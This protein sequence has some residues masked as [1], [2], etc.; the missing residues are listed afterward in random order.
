M[1]PG[2]RRWS[3]LLSSKVESVGGMEKLMNKNLLKIIVLLMVIGGSLPAT[4]AQNIQG[5]I[6]GM[7]SRWAGI[8]DASAII[9]IQTWNKS[10]ADKINVFYGQMYYRAPEKIRLEYSPAPKSATEPLL[11]PFGKHKYIYLHTGRKLLR[12]SPS[13]DNW[14][15]RL[16][17][18]PVIRMVNQIS[19]I[20]NFNINQFLANY[21]VADVRSSR[22]HDIPT[23][24]M[25]AE[26]KR[27]GGRHP[28]QL[29]WVHQRTYLPVEAILARADNEVSCFFHKVQ[30]NQNLSPEIFSPQ[31][32]M[33]SE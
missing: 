9:E 29:V 25:R 15:E 33:S 14:I 10:E 27:R 17:E 11:Y 26:P 21:T 20:N 18:D 6:E 16:G 3:I 12:Y 28:R 19:D 22:E 7:K 4:Q 32:T 5:V 23:Y 31:W 30:Q 8:R 1:F 13:Q 24:L 2:G